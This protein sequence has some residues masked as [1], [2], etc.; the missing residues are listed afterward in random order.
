MEI[1]LSPGDARNLQHVIDKLGHLIAGGL[2]SPGI[3]A[4]VRAEDLPVFLQQG[5]AE[6][7]QRPQR[8][9]QVVRYRVSERL[10]VPVGPL[11]VLGPAVQP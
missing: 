7:A 4:A 2:D 9:A 6:T 8:R 11:K 1:K 3:A 5:R 10:Q